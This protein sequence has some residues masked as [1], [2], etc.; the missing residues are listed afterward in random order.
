MLFFNP[1]AF[2]LLIFSLTC[3]N[4]SLLKSQNH[5]ISTNNYEE[6]SKAFD[7]LNEMLTDISEEISK[8]SSKF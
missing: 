2:F 8:K 5:L 7:I 3:L 4:S 1:K 6:A